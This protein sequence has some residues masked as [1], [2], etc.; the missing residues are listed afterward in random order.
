MSVLVVCLDDLDEAAR[1]AGERASVTLD[2]EQTRRFEAERVKLVAFQR[3]GLPR[4]R[5][6]WIRHA[7]EKGWISDM[8]VD[9][10]GSG[11]SVVT[12]THHGFA[13]NRNIHE[14]HALVAGTLRRL[15]FR[16]ARY[17][18]SPGAQYTYYRL[19]PA[20]DHCLATGPERTGC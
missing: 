20:P 11:N 12:F 9:G 3:Q 8:A 17:R 6:A 10:S 15:R 13:L 5:S 1:V 2:K 7:A 18:W 19:E 4:L 14:A 16:E